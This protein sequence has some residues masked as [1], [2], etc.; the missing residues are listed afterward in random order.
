VIVTVIMV[1]IVDTGVALTGRGRR[2]STAGLAVI[3]AAVLPGTE[4]DQVVLQ[5][6]SKF[7][8]E[9]SVIGVPVRH[10]S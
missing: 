10:E 6:H 7:R 1:V 3:P 5:R 9:R 4:L 8:C 2:H